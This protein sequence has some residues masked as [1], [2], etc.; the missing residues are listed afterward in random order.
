MA[1][2]V[3]A[4]NFSECKSTHIIFGTANADSIQED[5]FKDVIIAGAGNDTITGANSFAPD[6]V[7]AGPGADV[8]YGSNGNSFIF[9]GNGGDYLFGAGGNDFISGGA[10]DDFIVGDDAPYVGNDTLVG[11]AGNDRLIGQAGNDLLIGGPGQDLF[12]YNYFGTPYANL[13]HDTIADFTPGQ[14]MIGCFV[15]FAALDTNQNGV[16]DQGDANIRIV[17]G[18]TSIDFSAFRGDPAG[19]DVL[20]VQHVTGL[21]AANFFVG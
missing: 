1:S 7:F 19:T 14:D 21:T 9:G 4:A 18:G 5:G 8:V 15:A 12:M 20:N 2:N 3:G 6:V 16:L 11:G 17:S 13:G 10:G